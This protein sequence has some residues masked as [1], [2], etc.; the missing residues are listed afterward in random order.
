MDFKNFIQFLG[1]LFSLTTFGW[2][3][4]GDT[5]RVPYGIYYIESLPKQKL[6]Q[7]EIK[8]LLY[9]REE[10]KLARDVYLT[11]YEKWKLPIFR[12]I[13][14]S[15]QMHMN[16]L[17]TLIK[18]YGLKDPVINRIGA[19]KNQHLQQLYNKLVQQGEKSLID[20]LK[21]GALIEEIDIEDLKKAISLTDN[22]DLKIAYAN[23]MKGSRNHL[24]AFVRVLRRFGYEYHPKYLSEEEFQKIISTPIERGF[25]RN[26]NF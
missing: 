8:E 5:Q 16:I 15:E 23:L 12:N 10:E 6:S 13:A 3:F 26:S 11:L 18:K 20:A 19:F 25:I 24:R 21:V 9:M 17:G 22:K 1:V 14:R 7:E 2:H 4:W